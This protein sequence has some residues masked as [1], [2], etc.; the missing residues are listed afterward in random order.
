MDNCRR[1]VWLKSIFAPVSSNLTECRNNFSAILNVKNRWIFKKWIK[2][3]I[4]ELVK[5]ANTTCTTII[6]N[7]YAR[8]N[9]LWCAQKNYERFWRIVLYFKHSSFKTYFNL[10]H[11]NLFEIFFLRSFLYAH[12]M[13]LAHFRECTSSYWCY[14]CSYITRMF[15]YSTVVLF[16]NNCWIRICSNHIK[17]CNLKSLSNM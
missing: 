16:T 12:T 17:F 1:F 10:I 8:F 2:Q 3:T 7:I 6:W 4:S 11:Y 13:C 15:I 5:T 14:W 9:K